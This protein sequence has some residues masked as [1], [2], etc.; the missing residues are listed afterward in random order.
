MPGS[1]AHQIE[2]TDCTPYHRSDATWKE[3]LLEGGANCPGIWGV[4]RFR[5]M[6]LS[7]LP[8]V[9][10]K[11]GDW[12]LSGSFATDW[13]WTAFCSNRVSVCWTIVL[14]NSGNFWR[15]SL[16]TSLSRRNSEHAVTHRTE[17]VRWMSWKGQ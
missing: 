17:A 14:A 3:S 7:S 2:A 9:N 4:T 10:P 6:V 13:R 16:N 5:F 12:G 1:K 15:Q 11:C 8:Y